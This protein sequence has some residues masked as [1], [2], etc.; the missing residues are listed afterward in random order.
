DQTRLEERWGGWYVT[1][2]MGNLHHKGNAMVPL[3]AHEIG[4]VDS[5]LARNPVASAADVTSLAGKFDPEPYL[6]PDSD[7]VALLVLAHQSEI[8]NLITRA[9][10]EAS[11]AL[12]VNGSMAAVAAAPERLA[13]APLGVEA[14]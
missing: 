9:G 10:Y 5:Y 13:G 8:H 12:A 7:A 1:G 11:R 2:T 14:A 3:L 4:N 6:A